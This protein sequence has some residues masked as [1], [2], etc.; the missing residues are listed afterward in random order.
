MLT[1]IDNKTVVKTKHES[2]V[3]A[4]GGNAEGRE[5]LDSKGEELDAEG[6]ERARDV[7]VARSGRAI[8]GSS[9]VR[10]GGALA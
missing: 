5:E 4:D 2:A 7:R 8:S 1:V 9:A 6:R 10:G 3:R